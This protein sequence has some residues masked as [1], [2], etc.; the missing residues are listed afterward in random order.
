MVGTKY[1][2]VHFLLLFNEQYRQYIEEIEKNSTIS[3]TSDSNRRNQKFC[4]G[5]K[6]K[7]RG[8]GLKSKKRAPSFQKPTEPV[9]ATII[10]NEI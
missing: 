9:S 5:L 8:I 6:S 2:K 4:I 1:R 3:Q 7:K 10:F